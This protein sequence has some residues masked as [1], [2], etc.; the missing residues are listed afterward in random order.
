MHCRKTAFETCE[1]AMTSEDE[2]E[3]IFGEDTEVDFNDDDPAEE[4]SL[5]YPEP[6]PEPQEG[7]KSVD[8]DQE[9]EVLLVCE[10]GRPGIGNSAMAGTRSNRRRSM[11]D[12]RI[13]GQAG[14]HRSLHLELKLI[15]DVGLVGFPNVRCFSFY[16]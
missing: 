7:G 16:H 12:T 11:P 13:L 1:Q 2:L 9:N 4:D 5:A 8:L 6:R 14:Q 3:Y 15:A 10:G